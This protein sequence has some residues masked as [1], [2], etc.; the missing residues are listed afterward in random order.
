MLSIVD[1]KEGIFNILFLEP[2]PQRKRALYD[3]KSTK[4]SISFN[5]INVVDK[6]ELHKQ[7][8]EI[9]F[10]NLLQSNVNVEMLQSTIKKLE[11]Q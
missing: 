7:T 4:L 11:M 1:G 8:S 9:I 10:R 3:F 6:I 2:N 5:E